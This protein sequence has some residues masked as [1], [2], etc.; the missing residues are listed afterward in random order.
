MFVV[1]LSQ[2]IADSDVL[3]RNEFFGRFGKI[4]K[5]VVNKTTSYAGAQVS[6]Q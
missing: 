2:R 1:G 4:H 5:V 6:S 3:K